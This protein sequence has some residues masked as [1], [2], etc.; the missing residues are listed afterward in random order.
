[1]QP[2]G[3]WD[4]TGCARAA[5]T[6]CA[7]ASDDE[8]SEVECCGDSL[9]QSLGSFLDRIERRCATFDGD[10]SAPWGYADALEMLNGTMSEG[11]VVVAA[12][13]KFNCESAIMR[14]VHQVGV[15]SCQPVLVLSTD[16]RQTDIAERLIIL[17]SGVPEWRVHTGSIRQQDFADIGASI[18]RIAEAPVRIYV[19]D[20][21]EPWDTVARARTFGQQRQIGL[22]ILDS[23][24]ALVG[25]EGEYGRR[26]RAVDLQSEMKDLAREIN[27]PLLVMRPNEPW[28]SPSEIRE[29]ERNNIDLWLWFFG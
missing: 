10:R 20:W 17:D 3:A 18:S 24:D 25:D 21:D 12:P 26:R 23:L 4:K 22:I 13:P 28:Y 2:L 1:M 6:G 9:H 7:V 16:W 14:I 8:E 27:V 19:M 5:T 11:L 29:F 15:V